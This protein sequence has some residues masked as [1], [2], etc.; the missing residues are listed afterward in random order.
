MHIA[1]AV[2]SGQGVLASWNLRH[3]V[4]RRRGARVNLFN[5]TRG[6][7]TIEILTPP[8]P[9]LEEVIMDYFDYEAV[10]RQTGLTSAAAS[11]LW[12]ADAGT[13]RSSVPCA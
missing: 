7:P 4:N 13:Q 1:A 5:A 8:E 12:P 2:L 10:S 3:L 11:L 9:R 6:L